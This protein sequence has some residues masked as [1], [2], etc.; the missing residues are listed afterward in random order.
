VEPKVRLSEIVAA[1]TDA[2]GVALDAPE[3]AA[4]RAIL[5]RAGWEYRTGAWDDLLDRIIEGR[6]PPPGLQR[7][8]D[9][10]HD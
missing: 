3:A 5:A 7:V 8:I 4:A 6:Y 1:V 9:D 2:L 10:Y